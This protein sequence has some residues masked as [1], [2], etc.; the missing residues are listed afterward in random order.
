MERRASC[1]RTSPLA[2]LVLVLVLVPVLVAA[3]VVAAAR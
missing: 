1:L 3:V 2:V